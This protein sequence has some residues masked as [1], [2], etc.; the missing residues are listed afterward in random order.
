MY[1]HYVAVSGDKM[2]GSKSYVMLMGAVL[3]VGAGLLW[4]VVASGPSTE[5]S[6]ATI[7]TPQEPQGIGADLSRRDVDDPRAVGRVDA[8]VVLIEYADF[9]CPFCGVF[10]RETEP[11][12]QKYIKDGTLRIEFRDLAIFGEQ[13]TRAAAASRA[14]GEQGKFWDFYS[15]V[16]GDAPERGHANLT[17]SELMSYAAKI[18]IKNMSQFTKDMDS[19]T[20]ANDVQADAKEAYDIGASSTPLFLVNDEPILGAQPASVFIEKIERLAAAS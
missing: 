5:N 17:D 2:S 4:A 18:G 3:L 15:A 14:A 12:L 1:V 13:S 11:Q 16:Y 6:P 10:A 7:S 8:P 19:T 20:I 9:R